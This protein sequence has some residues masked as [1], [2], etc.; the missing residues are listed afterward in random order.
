MLRERPGVT[1]KGTERQSGL[2]CLHQSPDADQR[3]HPLDVVGQHLQCHLAAHVPEPPRQ[4][5]GGA[6]PA[7]I[8]SGY[9]VGFRRRRTGRSPTARTSGGKRQS[10][11]MPWVS[12]S[13]AKPSAPLIACKAFHDS[14]FRHLVRQRPIPAVH[15]VRSEGI[16][17]PNRARER[18]SANA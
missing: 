17:K 4:E 15:A 18:S 11:P 5:M 3:H 6:H 7:H 1:A 8:L 13:R 12:P 14:P 9:C 16:E 2:N 10:W